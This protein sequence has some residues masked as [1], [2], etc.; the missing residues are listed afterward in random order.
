VGEG[1]GKGG[2]CG[3]K[4]RRSPQGAKRK[5][6]NSDSRGF[7]LKKGAAGEGEEKKRS[8]VGG[9]KTESIK[10]RYRKKCGAVQVKKLTTIPTLRTRRKPPNLK[11]LDMGE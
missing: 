7:I 4:K 10:S 5:F 1:E 3:V 2:E 9:E 8:T 6:W 11:L